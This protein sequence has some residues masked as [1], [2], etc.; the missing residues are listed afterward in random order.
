MMSSLIRRYLSM[1]ILISGVVLL[2][3]SCATVPTEPLAQGELRLLSIQVLGGES[4][5]ANISYAVK[6]IFEADG[7]PEIKKACFY[8]SGDGPYCFRVTD[9]D[10]GPPGTFRV[11]LRTDYSG[12]Y[13][14]ECY[15]EYV[16]AGKSRSTNIISS[17]ITIR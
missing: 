1:A 12:F 14:L 7:K 2:F 8:W 11:W 13:K 5:R 6:I 10:F 9:V 16:R 15:V 3:S 4:I 17:Q